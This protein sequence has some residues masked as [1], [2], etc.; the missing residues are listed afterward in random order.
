[1]GID[2][3]ARGVIAS[4]LTDQVDRKTDLVF[5]IALAAL[6]AAVAVA[7]MAD[8]VFRWLAVA[9]ALLFLALLL[10]VLAT[11]R[12]AKGII[13]RFAPPIDIATSRQ[14]FDSAVVAADLPTGPV[15]LLRLV[16]RLR[17]GVGPE[18]TRLAAVIDRLRS[19][20]R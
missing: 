5:K 7:V 2:G 14:S 12:L 16:W 13:N 10:V 4:L 6:A 17:K 11:R 8:G 3:F 20:L 19:D 1:M 15:A 9:G 18:I